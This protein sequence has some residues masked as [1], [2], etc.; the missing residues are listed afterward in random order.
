MGLGQTTIGNGG[1]L[2]VIIELGSF[3]T[4]FRFEI[5]NDSADVVI[6]G[7]SFLKFVYAEILQG[8]KVLKLDCHL[9][10]STVTFETIDY[11]SRLL[12]GMMLFLNLVK[13]KT[14]KLQQRRF[15]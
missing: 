3:R 10:P 13:H 1:S 9:V 2:D 6:I 7:A 11:E 8:G 15:Q 5:I 4:K 12:W 14:V